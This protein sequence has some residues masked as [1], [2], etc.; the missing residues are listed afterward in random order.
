MMNSSNLR[1][2]LAN[3]SIASFLLMT[4]ERATFAQQ[5]GSNSN[6]S[7]SKRYS[8]TPLTALGQA[9][10]HG[11]HINDFEPGAINNRGDVIY[12]TDL[13]TS[14]SGGFFGEGVFLR[15]V[16]QAEMELARSTG[17]A[18]GGGTFDTLLL[19][20]TVLNDAGDGAFAF[21]LEPFGQPTGVNS[22]VYRLSHISGNVTPV[23]VPNVT[24]APA[25]GTFKGVAFNTS[26]NNK[27]DLLFS[28]II[29][30]DKG[31]H[32]PG[33]NYTGLGVGVFKADERDRITSIVSPGDAAPGGGHFDH[34]GSSGA[35][36]AWINQ[37]GDVAF[38]AH[39]AGE[40]TL[41]PNPPSRHKRNSSAPWGASMSKTPKAERLHRS[42]TSATR[43]RAGA[44]FVRSLQSC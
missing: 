21:T 40:E 17:P 8:F 7:D 15:R 18:P 25:G 26:L 23:V 24:D 33:Q 4:G 31:I 42:R 41:F 13:G 34:A 44:F 3:L 16:R 5:S 27:G 36:G 11:F 1:G 22:S 9:A 30:T 39:V 2:L 43:H 20:G 37:A 19:G 35:G 32:V 38:T 14:S 6:D 29:A 10:P 28:G 12:G